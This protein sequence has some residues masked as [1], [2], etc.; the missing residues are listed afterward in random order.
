MTRFCA[1]YCGTCEACR[2]AMAECEQLDATLASL[3]PEDADSLTRRDTD[4]PRTFAL[5]HKGRP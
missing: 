2:A 1:K 4:D 3:T 5:D